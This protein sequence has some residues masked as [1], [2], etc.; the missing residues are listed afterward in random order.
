MQNQNDVYTAIGPS[1]LWRVYDKLEGLFR[2]GGNSTSPQLIRANGPRANDF[3]MIFD[4]TERCQIVIPDASKGLSFSDSIERIAQIP[5][6]GRVWLLPKGSQLPEGLVFN[7]RTKDHPLL[8]VSRRMSVV[9]LTTKL[10]AVSALLKPT[11]TMIT[12][13]KGNS[14]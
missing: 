5:I 7:Y 8:N 12:R 14:K 9:D 10:A 13:P 6:A 11:D 3:T 4:V 2:G 1:E